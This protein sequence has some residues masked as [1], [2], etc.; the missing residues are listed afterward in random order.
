MGVL[1]TKAQVKA[2]KLRKAKMELVKSKPEI[3]YK[4]EINSK[5]KGHDKREL[6]PIKDAKTTSAKVMA[7][8]HSRTYLEDQS[9]YSR[10][11]NPKNYASNAVAAK[12]GMH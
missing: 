3:G 12:M 6:P 9:K 5:G 7:S 10:G 1:A 11:V 8:S 2:I 4:G